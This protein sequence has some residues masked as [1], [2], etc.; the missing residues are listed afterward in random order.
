MRRMDAGTMGFPMAPGKSTVV[1]F[2]DGTDLLDNPDDGTNDDEEE[3][4]EDRPDGT[5]VNDFCCFIVGVRFMVIVAFCLDNGKDDNGVRFLLLWRS[6]ERRAGRVR[7]VPEDTSP[8]VVLLL[9]LS[10]SSLSSLS[11]PSL[12]FASAGC[13]TGSGCSTARFGT[14]NLRFVTSRCILEPGLIEPNGLRFERRLAVPFVGPFDFTGTFLEGNDD[15]SDDGG[16]D[17]DVT[18][19]LSLYASMPMMAA[20]YCPTAIVSSTSNPPV[21]L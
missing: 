19:R 8:L 17:D 20:S 6:G 10:V 13:A 9:S 2:W 15:N 16:G 12:L 11:S 1:W 7:R 14:T 3:E 4:E 18:F 21:S 5:N